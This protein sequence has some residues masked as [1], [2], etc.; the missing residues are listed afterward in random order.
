MTKFASQRFARPRR[1]LVLTAAT[2]FALA[3]GS[4]VPLAVSAAPAAATTV[5]T[6]PPLGS[7]ANRYRYGLNITWTSAGPGVPNPIANSDGTITIGVNPYGDS[8]NV[9]RL[10]NEISSMGFDYVQVT[11]FHGAGTTLHPSTAL[12]TARGSGYAAST[13]VLGA[14]IDGLAV[15]GI[16]TF[17]FTHPLDGHDYSEAQQTQL[18]FNDP[19]NGYMKWNDFI[20]SFYAE[21]VDTYG[22]RIAGIGFDLYCRILKETVEKLGKTREI[23]GATVSRLPA[24]A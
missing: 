11:D 10:V 14:L 7:D 22:A 17:L 13:D 16:A 5:P 1:R 21:L 8:F 2:A 6:N 24:G 12:D 20:N 23:L 19:T 15:K 4:L 9:P 18:G 3:C